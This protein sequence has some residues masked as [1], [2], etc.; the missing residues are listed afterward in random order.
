M[1]TQYRAQ[2]P[3]ADRPAAPVLMIHPILPPGVPTPKS[4]VTATITVEANG[5]VADADLPPDLPAELA[6]VLRDTLKGWLFLPRLRNG[7]P[8][9]TRVNVPLKF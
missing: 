7:E 2:F 4:S 9:A 3:A 6:H 5:H 8:A 1:L